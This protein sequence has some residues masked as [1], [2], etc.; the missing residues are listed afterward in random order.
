MQTAQIITATL[1]SLDRLSWWVWLSPSRLQRDNGKRACLPHCSSTLNSFQEGR[2]SR[3]P[4][5]IPFPCSLCIFNPL[6]KQEQAAVRWVWIIC[7]QSYVEELLCP[8]MAVNT[9]M[10]SI[11]M[12]H[13]SG[14]AAG[15]EELQV[16]KMRLAKARSVTR[17]SPAQGFTLVLCYKGIGQTPFFPKEIHPS[18]SPNQNHISGQWARLLA[19]GPAPRSVWGAYNTRETCPEHTVGQ[20]REENSFCPSE[21]LRAIREDGCARAGWSS[22]WCLS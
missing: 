13:N 6:P 5:Q 14:T 9:V 3:I 17:H 7:S 16:I 21:Q 2:K 4:A 1:P 18:R 10:I 19:P 11:Y 12:Q 8:L 22:W 20:D 15:S